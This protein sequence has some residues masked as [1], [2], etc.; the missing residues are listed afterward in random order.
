MSRKNN[1]KSTFYFIVGKKLRAYD[2]NYDITDPGVIS[3]L[4]EISYRGHYIGLHPSYECYCDINRFSQ[5][6]SNLKN[7]CN[8]NQITLQ[9]WVRMH[10]LRFS[11]PETLRS[12]I[13]LE[14]LRTQPLDIL[15]KQ[16][17]DVV[18]VMIIQLL[19]L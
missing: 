10:Y 3:L 18:L 16:V 19:I 13:A 5:E 1:L 11:Y 9:D 14:L 12:K 2:A 8:K 17:F 7:V 15:I 6:F 4:K